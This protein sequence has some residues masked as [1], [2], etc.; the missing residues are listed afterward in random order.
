[1]IVLYLKT[2]QCSFVTAVFEKYQHSCKAQ[3]QKTK[4]QV[5]LE[6]FALVCGEDAVGSSGI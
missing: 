4:W 5:R 2:F 6:V 1:M 3:V